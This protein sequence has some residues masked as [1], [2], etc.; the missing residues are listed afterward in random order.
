MYT[1]NIRNTL[2]QFSHITLAPISKD[3]EKE[4]HI[5]FEIESN[6]LGNRIADGK[7]ANVCWYGDRN[8]QAKV[9]EL[10]GFVRGQAQC[11]T[12][13]N[14]GTVFLFEVIAILPPECAPS[15]WT[16]PKDDR[17]VLVLRLY[18]GRGCTWCELNE[19]LGNSYVETRSNGVEY[20]P[21]LTGMSRRKIHK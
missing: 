4:S 9:G 6:R 7:P 19:A 10:F 17:D 14:A 3:S 16:N 12:E 2:S 5:N 1:L 20:I 21:K 11:K 18:N 8:S 15:D 13:D